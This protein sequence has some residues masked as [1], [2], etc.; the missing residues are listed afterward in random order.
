MDKLCGKRNIGAALELLNELWRNGNVPS[1]ISCI[2]LIEGLRKLRKIEEAFRLMERM[3]KESIISDIVTFNYLLQDLCNVGRTVDADKLRLLASSKGLELDDMTYYTLVFGYTREGKRK[4][5]EVLVDEMLDREFIPDL[6][7]YNRFS[8]VVSL[9]SRKWSPTQ[10][11]SIMLGTI[12]IAF[13]VMDFASVAHKGKDR[14]IAG[15][16]Y[17]KPAF[18]TLQVA[19]EIHDEQN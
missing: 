16:F 19:A 1:V 17:T 6:A 11:H 15:V 8:A 12:I 9:A 7:T 4:E 13:V 18:K 3:L 14:E 2:T 10:P 5:G